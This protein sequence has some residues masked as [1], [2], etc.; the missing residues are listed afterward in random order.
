MDPEPIIKALQEAHK[1]KLKGVEPRAYHLEC[2]YSRDSNGTSFY[3]P[4]KY[5]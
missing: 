5:I 4:K 3:G 1:F 2:D